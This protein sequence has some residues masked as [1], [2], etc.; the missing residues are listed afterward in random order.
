[1]KRNCRCH[2]AD[3]LRST[4]LFNMFNL[5]RFS[6]YVDSF[7]YTHYPHSVYFFKRLNLIA[8]YCCVDTFENTS[9]CAVNKFRQYNFF[10]FFIR[11]NRRTIRFLRYSSVDDL[12]NTFLLYVLRFLYF[13]VPLPS[14]QRLAHGTVPS[15]SGNSP[16]N[17]QSF[18]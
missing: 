5:S 7:H 15:Q 3:Y 4:L 18:P 6:S 10:Y 1:M 13:F 17:F 11:L 9:N 16:K 2:D 12:S 8:N 14:L